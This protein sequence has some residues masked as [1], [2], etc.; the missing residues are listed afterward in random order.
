MR[1]L[2]R[3]RSASLSTPQT[4]SRTVEPGSM[5]AGRPALLMSANTTRQPL[6]V[7][8]ITSS[9]CSLTL[10]RPQSL[11]KRTQVARSSTP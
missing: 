2:Y 6:R 11:K 9:A 3:A 8:K 7:S 10:S 4:T 1:W 5:A